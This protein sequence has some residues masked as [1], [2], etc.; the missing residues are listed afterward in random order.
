MIPFLKTLS[1]C[2]APEK[3]KYK[4]S[5]LI[6]GVLDCKVLEVR[7][8]VCHV[9]LCSLGVNIVLVLQKGVNDFLNGRLI[10]TIW[11]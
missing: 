8:C 10:W 1:S 6:R 2:L 11:T 5:P 7:G 9:G 4:L 3:R